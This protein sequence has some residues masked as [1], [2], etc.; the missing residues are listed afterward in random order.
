MQLDIGQRIHKN[1]LSIKRE[2]SVQDIRTLQKRLKAI[3]PGLRTQFM[4]DIKKIAVVPNA[5]IKNAIPSEPPLSGMAGQSRVS[6]NVGKRSNSTTIQ[7]RTQ[8]NSKSLNTTLLRIRVNS[9]A[10]SIADMAG[11][12]GRSIGAGYR[13]SGMTREFVKRRRDG[14][15]YLTRRRTT[16]Q[17][18][19]QFVNSL[20]VDTATRPSRFA[21]KPVEKSLPELNR[22]VNDVI[23]RYYRIANFRSVRG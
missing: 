14:S 9:I 1:G 8:S 4:R 3:E 11:R 16:V 5:A 10:T 22:R 18:G 7:F 6:W 12:S 23:A 19:R 2:I 20:N 15:T 21:W 13:G 17:A